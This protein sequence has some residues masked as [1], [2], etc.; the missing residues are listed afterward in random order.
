MKLSGKIILSLVLLFFAVFMLIVNCEKNA[1]SPEPAPYKGDYWETV[2][3]PAE[4]ITAIAAN[5]AGNLL[6]G[7]DSS[8]IFSSSDRGKNWRK[9]PGNPQGIYLI[10]CSAGG[11]VYAAADSGKIFRT[12]LN[13]PDQEY[14]IPP[15]APSRINDMQVAADQSLLTA[16][17]SG[18]FRYS[19]QGWENL[20]SGLPD[21][22]ISAVLALPEGSLFAAA[23]DN[24][25]YRNSSGTAAWIKLGDGLPAAVI[26]GLAANPSGDLFAATY[27]AGAFV[28][29]DIGQNWNAVNNGLTGKNLRTLIINSR[30]YLFAAAAEG[31]FGSISSGGSWYS[32]DSGLSGL[33]VKQLAL[34]EYEYLYALTDSGGI[35]RSVFSTVR[36]EDP[37]R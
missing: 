19:P 28:S 12:S 35:F 17:A 31:V 36:V 16:T 9:L 37:L 22:S 6:A 11:T 15:S 13:A 4:R 23:A 18:L 10:L 32:L 21:T 24:S 34:D 30:G 33:S 14:L 29:S 3:Q 5:A 7:T 25:L 27:G 1:S 20:S 26:T 2:H 8:G